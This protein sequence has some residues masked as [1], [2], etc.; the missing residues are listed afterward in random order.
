MLFFFR[1]KCLFTELTFEGLVYLSR[2]CVFMFVRSIFYS[3]PRVPEL[4][5]E[6][7]VGDKILDSSFDD[8]YSL[9][10]FN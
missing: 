3:E 9:S 1:F 5:R 7:K 4:L 2:S 6:S 8:P 10:C